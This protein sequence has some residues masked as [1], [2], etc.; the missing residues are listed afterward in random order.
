MAS[1][2]KGS[3]NGTTK[4]WRRPA[5]DCESRHGGG[6]MGWFKEGVNVIGY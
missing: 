5:G 3:N 1:G 6:A 4:G 2:E